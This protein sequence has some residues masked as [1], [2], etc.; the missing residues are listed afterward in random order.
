[1]GVFSE[2]PDIY[3]LLSECKLFNMAAMGLPDMWYQERIQPVKCES[4]RF[5][6][7]HGCTSLYQAYYQEPISCLYCEG[8]AFG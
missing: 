7:L 8:L 2:S 6:L 1:M 4:V 3:T 5:I